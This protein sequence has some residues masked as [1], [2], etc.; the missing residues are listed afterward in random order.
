MHRI[1]H[2]HHNYND[3]NN[4]NNNR[5]AMNNSISVGNKNRIDDK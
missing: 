5:D 2:S 1:N 3:N 4:N